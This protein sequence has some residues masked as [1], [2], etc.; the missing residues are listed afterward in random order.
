MF[1]LASDEARLLLDVA[2]M[3]TGQ[4]RFQSAM[5]ILAALEPFRA[6]EAS[7]AVAKAILFISL[8]DFEGAVAYIDG[9]ALPKFPQ[10]AMLQAFKGMALLRL[11]RTSEAHEALALAAA[12]TEDPAAAQLAADLL[13][14]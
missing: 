13:P 8:Q 5:K 9:D 4:N 12:S 14:A 1:E 3:A 6:N 2:L 7:L 10:S 11:E